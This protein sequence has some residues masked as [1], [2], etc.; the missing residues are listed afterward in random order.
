MGR[1][2]LKIIYKSSWG[3]FRKIFELK[4]GNLLKSQTLDQQ[5]HYMF[6]TMPKSMLGQINVL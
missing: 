1:D 4:I 6:K 5:I 2:T 3:P